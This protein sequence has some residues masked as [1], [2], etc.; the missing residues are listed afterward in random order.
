MGDSI[1]PGCT[2]LQRM[3]SPAYW[4]AV[5][6]VSRRTAPLACGVRRGAPAHQARDG[7]DVHDGPTAGLPHGGDGRLGAKK[8]ALRVDVHHQVPFLGAGILHV[9]DPRNTG[10]VDQYVQ[11]AEPAD[12]G[13]HSPLP[14]RLV[15][16]VQVDEHAL[17]AALVY[18]S[19]G[20]AALLLQHVANNDPRPLQGEHPGL[21]GSHSSGPAA[22]QRY[23]SLESH[24]PPPLPCQD[25]CH[26][27]STT[28]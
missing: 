21:G 1:T 20:L 12:R 3:P 28:P 8:D 24:F 13:G 6:L 10:I 7:R 4:M 25:T 11:L 16:N 5:D 2:E 9:V 17:P 23:L 18:G 19:L 22:D 26:V 15:S 27:P 14:S